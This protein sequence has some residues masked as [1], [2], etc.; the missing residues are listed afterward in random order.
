MPV[1]KPRLN[2]PARNDTIVGVSPA[3]AVGAAPIAIA[4]VA[5]KATVGEVAVALAAAVEKVTVGVEEGSMVVV[6]S[7]DERAGGE[8][9]AKTL[10]RSN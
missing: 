6:V 8:R 9:E 1:A 4:E 7:G 3:E 5:A 10:N 2:P